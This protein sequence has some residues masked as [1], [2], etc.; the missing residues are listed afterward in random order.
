[1]RFLLICGPSLSWAR[2]QWCDF[3]LVNKCQFEIPYHESQKVRGPM[4]ISRSDIRKPID[5]V[6][7]VDPKQR[8]RL[9]QFTLLELHKVGPFKTGIVNT[10]NCGIHPS[11]VTF[12]FL[13][14]ASQKAL[15]P[16]PYIILD[17]SRLESVI[18]PLWKTMATKENVKHSGVFRYLA[19]LEKNLCKDNNRAYKIITL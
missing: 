17:Y 12:E 8:T 1:M 7:F 5:K 19:I 18:V 15:N 9:Y 3:C 13:T 14:A 4:I 2:V 10:R 11:S 16:T 6:K